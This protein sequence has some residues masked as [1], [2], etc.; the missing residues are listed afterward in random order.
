ML[1]LPFRRYRFLLLLMM[2]AVMTIIM[3]SIAVAVAIVIVIILIIGYSAE[4]RS[5]YCRNHSSHLSRLISSVDL[6]IKIHTLP[7]SLEPTTALK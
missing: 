6:T 1:L 3:L 5:L 2:M 7:P 4:A